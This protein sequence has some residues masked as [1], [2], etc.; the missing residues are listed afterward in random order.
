[1]SSASL[2]HLLVVDD[3]E[4]SRL[5]I[6]REALAARPEHETGRSAR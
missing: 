1:M 3:R 2:D 4:E 6:G 5:A